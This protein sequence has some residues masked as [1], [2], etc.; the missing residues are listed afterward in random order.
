MITASRKILALDTE[1]TGLD[2]RHSAR[3]FF[4]TFCDGAGVNTCFNGEVDYTTR[5]VWWIREELL[6]VL[7]LIRSVDTLVLQN[8]KFDF[9]AL[10][11]LYRDHGLLTEFLDAWLWTKVEDTLF[12]GHLLSS[13]T[14][15]DLT[16]MVLVD[17]GVDIQPLETRLKQVIN[18]ARKLAKRYPWQIAKEG[19]PDMPSAKGES[20]TERGAEESSPWAFDMAL[21]RAIAIAENLSVRP[22][23]ACRTGR[24]QQ[25]RQC[26]DA[27]IASGSPQK[28]GEP[29]LMEYLPAADE[30]G[31]HRVRYGDPGRYGQPRPARGEALRVH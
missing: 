27:A 25:C 28:A 19:L 31:A 16:S 18:E 24:V 12:S 13:N 20:K 26:H 4:I 17:L 29:G 15:H 8:A 14:P 21:P 2:L 22:R 30:A 6:E 3:P 23:V 11:S 5:K 7:R 10:Y 1:C 9:Q